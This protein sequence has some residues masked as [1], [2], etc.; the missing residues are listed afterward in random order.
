MYEDL[1]KIDTTTS[2]EARDDEAKQKWRNRPLEECEIHNLVVENEKKR[3]EGVDD[4]FE[5]KKYKLNR[6]DKIRIDWSM[7]GF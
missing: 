2:K 3:W 1:F 5:L 4:D 6:P 7:R